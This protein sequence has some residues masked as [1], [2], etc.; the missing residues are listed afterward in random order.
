MPI[1]L[2]AVLKMVYV[3]DTYFHIKQSL[4]A[5]Y[6]NT[7]LTIYVIL[8]TIL[9]SHTTTRY[10]IEMADFRNRN[11]IKRSRHDGLSAFLGTCGDQ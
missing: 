8:S 5:L 11:V 6:F 4:F 1:R 9:D 2:K 3:Y 10:T 7:F